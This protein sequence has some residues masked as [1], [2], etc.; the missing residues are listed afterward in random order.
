[1][2]KFEPFTADLYEKVSNILS[3]TNVNSCEYCFG[4]MLVWAHRHPAEIAIEEDTVFIRSE[5][6]EH[7]WYVYPEG[8]MDKTKAVNLILEDAKNHK[9]PS[10]IYSIDKEEAEFLNQNFSGKLNIVIDRDSA[11]YIYLREDLAELKGKK[12]QKKRNHVSKF[13]RENPNY[14]F[15]KIEEENIPIARKF[16]DDWCSEYSQGEWDL[17]SEKQ[18]IYELLDNYKKL[19]LIGAMILTEG[20]VIA[21]TIAQAINEETVDIMIEKAYHEVN[22]AYA[23]INRDFAINCLSDF[24]YINRE[25][26]MGLENLRKAKLSYFP[27]EIS[28][29]YM[30][31]G[32]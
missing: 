6:H 2:L 12:Y 24:K 28:E 20:K 18:G 1:M 15:L 8:E 17:I 5:G 14:E 31:Q 29:K 9:M 10:S 16:I 30:A 19:N 7:M 27:Y 26:D 4:T 13:L 23:I 22:G 32:I 25:D 11:D 21:I 3:K